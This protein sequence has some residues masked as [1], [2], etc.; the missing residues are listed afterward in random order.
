[1]DGWMICTGHDWIGIGNED[2]IGVGEHIESEAKMRLGWKGKGSAEP[3]EKQ[4]EWKAKKAN[5]KKVQ[6]PIHQTNQI[7][8][9]P[10][11]TLT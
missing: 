4:Q 3:N 7:N 9:H 1:M 11:L 6:P 10:Q 5:Q 2:G 8:N